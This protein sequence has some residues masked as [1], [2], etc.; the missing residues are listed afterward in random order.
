MKNIAK[1]PI[2]DEEKVSEDTQDIKEELPVEVAKEIKGGITLKHYDGD[3]FLF[4]LALCQTWEV[5]NPI[6]NLL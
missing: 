1:R 5:R 4:P 6:T 3:D 2:P